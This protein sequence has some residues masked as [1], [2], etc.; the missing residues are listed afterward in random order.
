MPRGDELQ[1]PF[2]F[3]D[4]DDDSDDLG[5]GGGGGG[6]G[7]GGYDDDDE[8]EGGWGVRDHTEDLWDSAEDDDDP[9]LAPLAQALAVEDVQLWYQTAVIGRRDIAWAPDPRLGF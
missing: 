1:E 6:G 7:G 4:R 5:Y 8:E 3:S 9:R 2:T